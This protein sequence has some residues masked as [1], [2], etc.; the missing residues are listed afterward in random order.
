MEAKNNF[1]EKGFI[2]ETR[3]KVEKL[4]VMFFFFF[5]GKKKHK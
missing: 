5:A 3:D 1:L 4:M 2:S